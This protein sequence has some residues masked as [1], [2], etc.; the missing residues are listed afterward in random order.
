MVWNNQLSRL[1]KIKYPF[2]QAPMLGFTTPEMVAAAANAGILGSLPLGLTSAEK[3]LQSITAVKKLTSSPFSVNLF[4]YAKK[5][6]P[7]SPDTS[8]LKLFYEDNNLRFPNIPTEDPYPSYQELIEVIIEQKIPVV[9]FTFGI[10]AK[11]IIEKLKNKGIILI[12][13]ATSVEEAKQIQNKGLNIAVAQGIEAG[14]HRGSFNAGELPQ[15]GLMSLLP[16]VIDEVKIPV[17]GAGG[18]SQG[19]GIAAAFVLGA[20][21]VQIGSAFLRSKESAA[22]VIHK[23]LISSLKDTGTVLT[24]AWTGRFARMIPN[25]F[26]KQLPLEQILPYPYQ[27]YMSASL[28]QCGKEQ[29]R[30][31]IQTLYAGQSAKYA[32]D[33]PVA[34]IIKNLIT[35]AEHSLDNANKL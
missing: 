29:N 14:G 5:V 28:R 24:N 22:S 10:P 32:K 21:G 16:Q 17:I 9:S 4:V 23:Q 34:E 3:S 27:N 2:I 15:I 25:D 18:L 1:L 19:R 11:Y 20:Q 31:D 12:G 8:T 30:S 13:V 6:A 35:S 7:S 26:I 33:E